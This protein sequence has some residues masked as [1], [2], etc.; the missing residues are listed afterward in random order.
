M[1]FIAQ[2]GHHISRF[3]PASAISFIFVEVEP[4]KPENPIERSA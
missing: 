1:K 2:S 3:S 4:R